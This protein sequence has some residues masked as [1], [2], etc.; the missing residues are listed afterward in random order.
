MLST[1]ATTTATRTAGTFGSTRP[2]TIM[3]ARDTRPMA[4]DASTTS[5]STTPW[6]TPMTSPMKPSAST[7]NPSSFGSCPTR[8]VSAR[9]FM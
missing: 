2:S 5:P 6:T 3:M 4:A 8:M 9:P 1:M 7:E